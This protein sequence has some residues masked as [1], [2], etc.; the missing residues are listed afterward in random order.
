MNR[1]RELNGANMNIDL[2][3]NNDMTWKCDKCPWNEE[4]GTN[5][6]KCAVKDVS[7]CKY[8]KGIKVNN[9]RPDIVLCTYDNKNH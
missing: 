8:F 3:Q 4:E 6:H 5:Q 7:I 1:I 2:I 9:K